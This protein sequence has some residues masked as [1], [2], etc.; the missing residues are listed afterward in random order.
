MWIAEQLSNPDFRPYDDADICTAARNSIV[1]AMNNL[2]EN[3]GECDLGPVMQAGGDAD[4]M[5]SAAL[6][7]CFAS[8]AAQQQG[9]GMNGSWH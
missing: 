6:M 1:E 7:Q 9:L 8:V 3:Q 4:T 5:R 2:N